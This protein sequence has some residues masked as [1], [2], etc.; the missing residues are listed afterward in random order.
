MPNEAALSQGLAS[1]ISDNVVVPV[2]K[3]FKVPLLLRRQ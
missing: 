3:K 1:L 2:C